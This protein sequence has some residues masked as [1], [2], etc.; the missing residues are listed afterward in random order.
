MF[1][2]L[3]PCRQLAAG[4]FL[5]DPGPEF[6]STIAYFGFILFSEVPGEL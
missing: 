3:A 4:S 1:E 2:V 5:L 6:N